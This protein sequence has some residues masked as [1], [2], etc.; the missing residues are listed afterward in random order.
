MTS[1]WEKAK[2]GDSNMRLYMSVPENQRPAGAIVVVQGQTGVNDMV[3]FSN[4]AA[5]KGFIAAAKCCG[6]RVEQRIRASL[7]GLARAHHAG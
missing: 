6:P 4:L 3:Q 1:S 2:I 7:A 5:Q